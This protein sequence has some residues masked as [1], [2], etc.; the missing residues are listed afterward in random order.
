MEVF[1]ELQ[2]A[3]D[4]GYITETK[5]GEMRP[6]IT[7]IAKMLS[8]LRASLIKKLTPQQPSPSITNNHSLLPP[9]ITNNL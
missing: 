8:G 1:C 9:S 7:D 6:Q 3:T 2:T 5:L 4:L